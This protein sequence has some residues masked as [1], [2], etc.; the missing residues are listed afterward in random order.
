[1]KLKSQLD[2]D[3]FI[4]YTSNSIVIAAG[5]NSIATDVDS[6][7]FFTGPVSFTA[8]FTSIR[9]GTMFKFN[10]LLQFGLPSS[11]IT[12]ISTFNIEP[13]IKETAAYIALTG[14]IMST[15]SG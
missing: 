1:M 5:Q 13:P 8:P 15:A 3:S 9:F 4:E 11:M 2:S 10:P 7:N 14:L 6:G 12:P